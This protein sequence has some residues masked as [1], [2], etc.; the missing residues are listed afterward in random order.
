M[1]NGVKKSQRT[2][3]AC[4]K[5]AIKKQKEEDKK[6][7]LE[8]EREKDNLLAGFARQTI[9]I[10]GYARKLSTYLNGLGADIIGYRKI[11]GSTSLTT[12]VIRK[13]LHELILENKNKI[14][15]KL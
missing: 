13:N 15:P 1:P 3:E 5:R 2:A 14:A 10:E 7:Q 12:E 11:E 8:A 4:R 9:G 6:K